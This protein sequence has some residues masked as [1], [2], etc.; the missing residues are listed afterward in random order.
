MKVSSLVIEGIDEIFREKLS[1]LI[2]EG[3]K[4]INESCTI[5]RIALVLVDEFL[6]KGAAVNKKIVTCTGRAEIISLAPVAGGIFIT[7]LLHVI[8]V[9]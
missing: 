5:N 3:H 6:Y 9:I 4:S 1:S 8:P 7:F 2:I